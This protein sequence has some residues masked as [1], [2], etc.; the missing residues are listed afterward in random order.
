MTEYEFRW[1][2]AT[3]RYHV[4][5]KPIGSACNLA[6]TYCY[7]LSKKDLLAQAGDARISDDVLEAYVRQ[8]IEG[9]TGA[10]EVVFSWQGGE[11]TLLGLDFFK[12][13]VA[14]EK[15]YARAGVRVENDLQTNGVLLDDEWCRFLK[16]NNFLVGLSVDGPRRFHDKYRVDRAGNG[17]FDRVVGAARLLRERGVRFNTLTCVNRDNARDPLAVYRFLRDKLGAVTMQFIPIVEPKT[18]ER[19]APQRWLAEEMPMLGTTAALPGTADSFVT[20]WSVDPD[21]WGTFLKVIFDEWYK[22]DVGKTWIYLFES[23][24]YT[25]SGQY[26]PLCIFAPLCG[27]CLALE[28]DGSLYSCDHYVYPEYRLGNILNKPIVE[29]AFSKRQR[30][31]A[32]GKQALTKLCQSCTFLKWCYGECCKNR[33]LR[34]PEGEPGHNYLCVGYKKFFNHVEGRVRELASQL[35]GRRPG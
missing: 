18:F 13:V 17:S 24:V 5:C 33:F 8:N 11:P 7:Y 10:E 16:E 29:L 15:K 14:L 1:D 4:M 31:F 25:A 34:T 28:A 23:A 21:D 27:K 9:Q 12:K 20:D 32:N 35:A 22:R 30:A 2:E 6:C 3:V 19:T 26:S